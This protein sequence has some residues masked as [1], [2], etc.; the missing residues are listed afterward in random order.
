M[1]G[2]TW[3]K[4]GGERRH[5]LGRGVPAPNIAARDLGLNVLDGG[6]RIGEGEPE[7]PVGV[8]AGRREIQL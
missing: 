6:K 7:R 2:T 8:A 3:R 1:V 4:L 5:P